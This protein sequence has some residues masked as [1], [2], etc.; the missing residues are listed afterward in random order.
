MVTL[1]FVRQAARAV[2]GNNVAYVNGPSGATEG[3]Y[4]FTVCL[5]AHIF[6]ST[7]KLTFDQ[8]ERFSRALGTKLINVE[9]E[10]GYDISDV[11]PGP[12]S[13]CE[14]VVSYPKEIE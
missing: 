8:L 6:G 1:D 5:K 4:M 11:T 2:F 9:T 14:L 12:S 3:R 13:S 10:L 7:I